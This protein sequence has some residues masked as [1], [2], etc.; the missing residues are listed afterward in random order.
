MVPETRHQFRED[1]AG[2][3]RKTLDGLEMVS[4]AFGRALEAPEAQRHSGG[5]IAGS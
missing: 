3:E 2:L 5:R 4:K 1:L